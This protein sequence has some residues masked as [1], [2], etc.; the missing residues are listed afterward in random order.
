MSAVEEGGGLEV[1][2]KSVWRRIESRKSAR[3]YQF[4]TLTVN[5]NSLVNSL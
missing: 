1:E 5:F 3:F 2:R 4:L